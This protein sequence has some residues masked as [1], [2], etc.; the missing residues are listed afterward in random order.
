M[1]TPTPTSGATSLTIQ[2]AT[3]GTSADNVT[4]SQVHSLAVQDA[5]IGTTADNVVMSQA[6][7]LAIQ[8]AVMAMKSDAP[9]LTQVHQIAI[10]DAFLQTSADIVNMSGQPG[11][12]GPMSVA[13]LQAQKLPALTGRVGSVQDLLFFYYGGL[14]G[15][16]PITSYSVSDHQKAYYAAQTALPGSTN[17]MA[18]LEKAF[19]DGLLVPSGSLADREFVYWTGL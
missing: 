6:I 12:G 9:D 15:L 7:S 17:S 5:T 8:K 4:L 10:H 19:Y 16:S 3:I 11:S 2:D 18:D 1:N 13:D 14:S